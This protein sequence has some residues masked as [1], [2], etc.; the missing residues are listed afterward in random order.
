MSK[1]NKSSDDKITPPLFSE[2]SYLTQYHSHS[3]LRQ[4]LVSS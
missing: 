4:K 3:D 1:M 2:Q